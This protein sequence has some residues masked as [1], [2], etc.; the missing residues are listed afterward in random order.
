[1]VRLLRRETGDLGQSWRR[2]AV[3]IRGREISSE[4]ELSQG[5]NGSV[6]SGYLCGV[7]MAIVTYVGDFPRP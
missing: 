6:P 7:G 1:M 3:A 5:P 2:I 4:V